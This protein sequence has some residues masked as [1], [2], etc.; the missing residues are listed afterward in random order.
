[1]TRQL[2]QIQEQRQAKSDRQLVAAV[3]FDLVGS[4]AHTGGVLQGFSVK[5]EDEDCLLILRATVA[6]RSQ[7]S[8]VGSDSLANAFRKA[9]RE[10]KRDRLKWKEDKYA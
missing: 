5:L 2:E 10:A 4:V 1:M 7:V 3:E 6:G 8:F 9:V